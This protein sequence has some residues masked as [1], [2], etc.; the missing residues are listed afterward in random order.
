M[1]YIESLVSSEVRFDWFFCAMASRVAVF[2]ASSTTGKACVSALLAR[3]DAPEVRAVFRSADA[4]WRTAIDDTTGAFR[5][6]LLEVS[7]GFDGYDDGDALAAAFTGC[8]AAVIV[9]PH[10]LSRGFADDA[11][12]AENMMVA[13]AAAGVEHIV[14]IGSWTV[15]AP[16]EDDRG[17]SMLANRF[18][19]PEL[20]LTE[21]K[22]S[23]ASSLAWT[24]LRSGSFMG[25]NLLNLFG[26]SLRKSDTLYFPQALAFPPVDPRDVGRVAAAVAAEGPSMHGGKAY[27]VSGPEMLTTD[28]MVAIFAD[29]LGRDIHLPRTDPTLDAEAFVALASLPPPLAQLMGYMEREGAGAIPLSQDVRAVTGVDAVSLREWVE[30]HAEAFAIE[31]Q[32]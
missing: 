18:V 17:V 26:A 10:D 4:A 25:P 12:L 19:S 29:V 27:E 5:S 30:E 20:K 24:S 14:S 21:L 16:G 28:E 8:D 32:E 22:S 13:A 2:T 6:E 15:N 1:T 3:P 23:S 31:E 11:M 7:T 9:A